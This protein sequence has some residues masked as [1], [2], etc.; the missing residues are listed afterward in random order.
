MLL[1][2]GLPPVSDPGALDACIAAC[3]G[4]CRV[5]HHEF[6]KFRECVILHKKSCWEPFFVSSRGATRVAVQPQ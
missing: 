3:T 1:V 6:A 5:A 4:H 2:L